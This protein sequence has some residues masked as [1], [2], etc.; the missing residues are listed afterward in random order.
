[1]SISVSLSCCFDHSRFAVFSKSRRA[2]PPA[3]F[4]LFRVVLAIL[5]LLCF[6]LYFRITGT[7]SV[8]NVMGNLIGITL[9][10]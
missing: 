8:E 5:G 7:S 9:K 3:L 6:H 4:F 1:M 2:M 10:L